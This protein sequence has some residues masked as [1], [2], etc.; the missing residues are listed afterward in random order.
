MRRTRLQWNES[1]IKSKDF[2]RNF[3]I[4]TKNIKKRLH[5]QNVCV[6]ISFVERKLDE[7]AAVAEWQTQQTQNLPGATSCEFESRL[8]HLISFKPDG[9]CMVWSFLC[10]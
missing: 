5:F 8:R 4:C 10:F 3:V 2:K 9:K 6:K 7:F 1:C